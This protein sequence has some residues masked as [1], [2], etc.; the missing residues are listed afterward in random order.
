[1]VFICGMTNPMGTGT[2]MNFYPWVRVRVQISTHSLFAGRRVI[3][4]PD[5]NS[6]RCHPLVY[7]GSYAKLCQGS[8]QYHSI[9][10]V[11][12]G[13]H[14]TTAPLAPCEPGWV[15]TPNSNSSEQGTVPTSSLISKQAVPYRTHGD[16]YC[17]GV[18]TP[19]TRSIA[20]SSM[21]NH[22]TWQ[23]PSVSTIPNLAQTTVSNLTIVKSHLDGWETKH[24]DKDTC[25]TQHHIR[26]KDLYDTHDCRAKQIY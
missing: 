12:R 24:S 16:T 26:W 2:G 7:Y 23:I 18:S 5:P 15:S 6:T 22:I 8:T 14:D 9:A 13:S 1:V 20:D 17:P 4:L 11:S 21:T 25:Q 19:M 10:K 3:A